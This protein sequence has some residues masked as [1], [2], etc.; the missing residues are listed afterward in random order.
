MFDQKYLRSEASK[1]ACSTYYIRNHDLCNKNPSCIYIFLLLVTICPNS[2]S[3]RNSR[4]YLWR[5]WQEFLQRRRVEMLLLMYILHLADV[6]E[7]QSMHK[8]VLEKFNH[9]ENLRG[10]PLL[11]ILVQEPRHGLLEGHRHQRQNKAHLLVKLLENVTIHVQLYIYKESH[12]VIII[13]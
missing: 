10:R 1:H 3:S 13:M 5:K 4:A 2:T 12:Q 11:G 6:E 9:G 7:L 8:W